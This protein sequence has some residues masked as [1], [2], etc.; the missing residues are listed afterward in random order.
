MTGFAVIAVML[1]LVALAWII[2]PLARRGHGA[3]ID[4]A[5]SNLDILRDQ[6]AEIEGDLAAGTITTAQHDEARRE[7][8]RRVLEEVGPERERSPTPLGGRWTAL[9]LGVGMSFAAVGLYFQLGNPDGLASRSAGHDAGITHD[10]LN[11]LIAKLAAKLEQQPDE[12]GFVMLARSYYSQRRYAEAVRAFGR[13]GA[14]VMQDP[15]LL[16]DYADALAVVQDGRLSGQPLELVKRAIA[17]EPAHPKALALAGTEA[18][19]RKDYR[20]AIGLWERIRADSDFGQMIAASIEEARELGG[21]KASGKSSVPPQVAITAQGPMVAQAQVTG[22]AQVT[23]Q[24]QG[25]ARVTGTV[26]LAPA[27]AGKV[28]REDT[29]FIFARAAEGPRMPLAIVKRQVKDLP[30]SFDLDDSQAMAPTMKL[31]GA[32]AVIV[33]ARIS[34]SGDAT[35]RSGDLQGFSGTVKVGA[36]NIAIVI[37]SVVP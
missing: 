12:A 17:V 34:K 2:V 19:Q 8:E 23:A 25:A 24:A 30:F 20:S 35:P 29:L 11:V 10:E 15:D 37:D 21:I 22:Q 31:S 18:F 26:K 36:T 32:S 28:D 7:I 9:A 14:M 3:G 13:A 4:P 6:L 16:S 33:G 27:L 1:L 5:V